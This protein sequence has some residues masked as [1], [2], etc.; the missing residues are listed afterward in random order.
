MRFILFF[1]LFLVAC[2]GQEIEAETTDAGT[3]D[4][5][6]QGCGSAFGEL[7]EGLVELAW[8]DAAAV[9]DISQQEWT[10]SG[11]LMRRAVLHEAVRFDL[12]RPA[13]V[14]GFAVQWGNL[15]SYAHPK[16]E[17]SAGLYADF[18][19][20]GFDL[21]PEPMWQGSRCYEDVIPGQWLYYALDQ[22]I[23]LTHPG[24]LYVG[25]LRPNDDGEAFLFDGTTPDNGS[26]D[27]FADCHSAFNLPEADP[28]TYNGISF[29][30]EY[31]FMVRL[32][33]EYTDQLQPQ[34]MI[35]QDVTADMAL[36]NR[37]AWGDYNNDGHDDLFASSQ[38]WRN[39]NGQFVDVTEAAGLADGT[40]KSGA[41]WGDYDNDGCLDL[42][43]FAETTQAGDNLWH[44]N[45]DGTFSNVTQA[46]GIDDVQ[47]YNLCAD[48]PQQ[49]HQP[50][51]AA[52][53]WDLNGDGYL[54]LY[55]V[56][57]I[58][59]AD[60]DFYRD[61]IFANNGDGTF[62]EWTGDF[63]FLQQAF[64][65]RGA[66]PVD[67][68]R[69]GD[70]DLLVNDYTLQRNLFFLNNGDG[71][72]QEVALERN[73]AGHGDRRGTA[74]YYGH[75]IG[76]AWG[77]LDSDGDFDLVEANLAH[78]R[79]FDF[80]DKTRVLLND[81]DGFFHDTC[82]DWT[83]PACNAGLRFQETHS[84]P[85]LA[86]FDNDGHLDLVVSAV[87]NG[88]PT[89][90][91]WGVGDGSFALDAYHAGIEV[92][93]GWGMAAADFDGDGAPDLAAKGALYRNVFANRQNWLV[94]RAIGNVNS[95]WGAI[96]A[97][98]VVQSAGK[99]W[100]RHVQGGSGQ[101]NQDS[102]YLHFGLGDLEQV[103]QIEV[104]FPGGGVVIYSGPFAARQRL[105]LLED[106]QVLSGQ[107][108]LSRAL[109]IIR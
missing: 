10:V 86:D 103:E 106:G 4:A 63:G 15:L 8:D 1:S 37:H 40:S 54:D 61:Q 72:V 51:P 9:S 88:R 55:V 30:F 75:T 25:H 17:I 34:Q 92:T 98:V 65:G 52:A 46:A 108:P 29:S 49:N 22:P 33:V 43:V 28:N 89:D 94:V 11:N 96:G 74:T 84:V 67:F 12:T 93:D 23:A 50:S 101:G 80:S 73:L 60:R 71:S 64:S 79:F 26:C 48:E 16:K 20:N 13:I 18:G 69:D 91:Y 77:D 76:A 21:W 24:L 41:V 3:A 31:D 36:G 58:C 95:N 107:R 53:W 35:F 109:P 87:Y 32:Y 59:W 97:T 19:Y 99:S 2:P 57:F 81:G 66:A 6:P 70:V 100:L 47:D 14:H 56:G 44:S 104:S 5:G 105:W 85:V 39:N 42:F 82:G 102:A 62:S 83:Y 68:D 90:F 38:L 78:P 27:A 45:C 7:P